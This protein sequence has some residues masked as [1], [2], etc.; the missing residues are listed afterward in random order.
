MGRINLKYHH[1]IWLV[2]V[3]GWF[4]LYMSRMAFS[5]CIILIMGEFQLTHIEA[6][7]LV[8]AYFYSYVVMQFTA[9]HLGDR[10]GRKRIL[11]IGGFAMALIA[12]LMGFSSTFM[13]LFVL[14]VFFGFTQGSY[15]GNDRSIISYYTPKEKMGIGQALG[16]VGA[17][18]GL[19]AGTILGGLL[20]QIFGWRYALTLMAVPL[21][22]SATLIWK[23]IKEPPSQGVGS[24]WKAKRIS[25]WE[26]FK[27]RAHKC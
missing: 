7:F 3:F 19:A 21:F 24:S 15:F 14:R 2:M 16:F 9:G 23:Y 13:L 17:G 10:F 20:T 27:P 4:T 6:V 1:I 26:I 8:S 12:L 5:P 18:L 22:L 11:E 25:Y